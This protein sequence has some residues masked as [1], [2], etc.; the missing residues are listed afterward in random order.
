MIELFKSF[1]DLFQGIYFRSY[2]LD[3][4]NHNFDPDSE[5]SSEFRNSVTV[6]GVS[7]AEMMFSLH[8][9]FSQIEIEKAY[10]EITEIQVGQMKQNS[11]SVYLN[12]F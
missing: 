11:S 3:P 2:D 9:R 5:T 10:H 4:S 6:S 7:S 1:N 8:K 12:L